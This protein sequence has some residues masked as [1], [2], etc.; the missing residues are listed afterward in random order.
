MQA[1]HQMSLHRRP[2]LA[3]LAS[4]G[5]PGFA[6][7]AESEMTDHPLLSGMS[8]FALRSKTA[9]EAD[10]FVLE[11]VCGKLPSQALPWLVDGK[12]T[13][14]E[15]RPQGKGSGPLAIL[16]S[17]Q[18]A[19]AKAGGQ[20]LN[21]GFSLSDDGVQYMPHV[22]RLQVD[23]TPVVVVL[24][25]DTSNY[26]LTI[27]E[28]QPLGEL[29]T[30]SKLAADLKAAGV[31]TLHIEFE[32]GKSQLPSA[33]QA[34]VKEIAT[35]LRNAPELQL[36]IEGHTD[37]VGQAADNLRLSQERA[38][39]VMKAVVAQGI[40]A[41][42]LKAVGHGQNEPVADNRTEEGRAKNRRVELVKR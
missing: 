27:I 24:L 8:G 38:E 11:K 32:T 29:V 19:I 30:A 41:K 25:L 35:L 13:R 3:L 33:G 6:R 26:Q 36:S 37:R 5:L 22:F 9:R 20:Q 23:K 4:A 1:P 31:A 2:L 10:T 7:A 40:E 14:M 42:R 12:V 18:Q 21:T 15:Y 39:A 17:Y 16:R 34:M 28:Q